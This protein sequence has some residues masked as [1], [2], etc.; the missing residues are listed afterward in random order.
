V[1]MD[2]GLELTLAELGRAVQHAINNRMDISC[3]KEERVIANDGSHDDDHYQYYGPQACT[4][5][6]VEHSTPPP[7][8]AAPQRA[9]RAPNQ[10]AGVISRSGG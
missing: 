1:L 9:Q 7:P 6:S 8:A 5:P 4:H 10:L 2:D 3:G